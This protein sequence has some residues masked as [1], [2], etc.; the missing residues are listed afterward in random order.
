[1]ADFEH[2]VRE[3]AYY[4]WEDEGRAFGHAERHWLRAERELHASPT[5]TPMRVQV[6]AP[7]L[8]LSASPAEVLG[9]SLKAKTG[10]SR[11]VTDTVEAKVKASV[12]PTAARKTAQAAETK[13]E[14]AA[15][16]AAPSKAA[17]SK[18]ASTKIAAAKI[19]TAKTT[20]VK[21][22]AVKASGAQ[23]SETK[24]ART[25][26]SVGRARTSEIVATVH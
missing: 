13:P 14:P 6:V 15:K 21:T 2:Q 26:K 22:A 1:M 20:T 3:R 7:D 19:P 4:I 17:N 10:R 18:A 11:S 16:K 12:K 5:Q 23:A 25:T 9:E 24:P 8:T